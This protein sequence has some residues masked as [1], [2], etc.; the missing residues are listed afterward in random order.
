M[1]REI[2]QK[3]ELLVNGCV[4]RQMKWQEGLNSFEIKEVL[5]RNPKMYN[6]D[7]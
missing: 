1:G 2:I 3:A 6:I 5:L 4:E 7:L